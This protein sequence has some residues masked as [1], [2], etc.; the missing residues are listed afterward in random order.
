MLSP[1]QGVRQAHVKLQTL[2]QQLRDLLEALRRRRRI[3][4]SGRH[5]KDPMDLSHPE[6]LGPILADPI[7]LDY[8]GATHL[9]ADNPFNPTQVTPIGANPNAKP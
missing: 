3:T 9:E 6:L 1:S 8:G 7:Y 2:E 4:R 5:G